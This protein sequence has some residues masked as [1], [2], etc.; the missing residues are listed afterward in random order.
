[1]LNSQ[2]FALLCVPEGYT[3]V[4]VRAISCFS[5]SQDCNKG[6]SAHLKKH[7]INLLNMYDYLHKTYICYHHIYI[8]NAL[9]VIFHRDHGIL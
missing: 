4:N 8:H 2:S 5:R 9:V 3:D 7:T 1:M 6:I